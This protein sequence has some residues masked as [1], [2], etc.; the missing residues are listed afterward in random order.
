MAETFVASVASE[1]EG[2]FITVPDEV[3]AR[4]SPKRRPPVRVTVNGFTFPSTP[5]IYG[6]KAY[7]PLRREVREKAGIAPGDELSVTLE[8]DEEPRTVD[9]PPDLDAEL[10]GAATARA[11]LEALSYSNRK[12]YADWVA[13][14]R[15][16]E[17]RQR[18]AREAVRLLEQGIRTP[19]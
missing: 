14:A 9:L 15:K 10:A 7:L 16:P 19:R 13:E 4:L 3:L 17:T 5:A 1:D 11:A 18:R 12:E 2:I 6:G 8:L